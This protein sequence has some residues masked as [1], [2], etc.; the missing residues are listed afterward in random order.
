MQK[1][2]PLTLLLIALLTNGCVPL[3]QS[4]D[5][6]S[7]DI[8]A[9]NQV[10]PGGDGLY[11]NKNTGKPIVRAKSLAWYKPG[12][13]AIELTYINGRLPN[14]RC[15]LPNGELNSE[16]SVGSGELALFHE[17]GTIREKRYY[18]RGRYMK[19]EEYSGGKVVNTKDI[20]WGDPIPE[21]GWGAFFE[22][23][24]R[25]KEKIWKKRNGEFLLK[26]LLG[27]AFSFGV[28]GLIK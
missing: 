19:R 7:F 25:A 6:N 26:L 8:I 22:E 14:I 21:D 24:D 3:R 13:L 4:T 11:E 10:S 23:C 28:G 9:P 1:I 17:D 16:I 2:A 12:K 27:T 15:Y 18:E 20:N 5:P